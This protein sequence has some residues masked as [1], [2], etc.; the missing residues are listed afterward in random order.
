MTKN[1][2]TV[3]ICVG[4]TTDTTTIKKCL[5]SIAYGMNK[6]NPV[7]LIT[8]GQP[9]EVLQLVKSIPEL[10]TLQ[11][12]MKRLDFDESQKKGWITRKKNLLVQAATHE[13]VL[14]IHDY[15]LLSPTF[16]KVFENVEPDFDILQP[17]ILTQEDKRHSDWII[18]QKYLDAIMTQEIA[19]Q[20]V[21]IAPDDNGPRWV[22]GVP[23]D[24]T[25]L[26]HL[27]YISGGLALGKKEIFLEVPM[28]ETHC[29]G[30][31]EDLEWSHELHR[32]E[33]RFKM[34]PDLLVKCGKPHKWNV[35]QMPP[36]TVELLKKRFPLT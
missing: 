24:E 19:Q 21:N 35:R 36:S 8:I 33:V 20:H 12:H 34:N 9:N 13:N 29:W 17:R 5:F 11:P 14:L 27:L 7:E 30:D 16:L 26:N 25:G 23:Y 1:N 4:P 10:W 15:Y 18:D 22:C 3:G 28:P 31:A 6:D 32:A 2:L